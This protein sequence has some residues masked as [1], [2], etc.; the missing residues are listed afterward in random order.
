MAYW[1]A[2]GRSLAA[3]DTKNRADYI[4]DYLSCAG[5]DASVSRLPEGD[6]CAVTVPSSQQA[7]ADRLMRSYYA[8]QARMENERMSESYYRE[9]CLA[10]QPHFIPQEEKFRT[11]TH[12]SMLYTICG[13]IVFVLAVFHF[14]L[15]L[16]HRNPDDLRTCTLEL[17]LA[18]IFVLFGLS[19]QQKVRILQNK[20]LEENSFTDG[21]IRWCTS[22][23]S[24]EHI[25]KSIQA[26]EDTELTGP[27]LAVRR[28]ELIRD[29]ILREYDIS[30][31][32][33]LDY[34]TDTIYKKF[35]FPNSISGFSME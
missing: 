28:R 26:A 11:D 17:L 12:S 35:Y 34:I 23:Y 24:A 9:H 5:L 4:A 6:L 29:Y 18:C 31:A 16:R 15:M 33:Y 7:E 10:R 22:T 3:E 32:A 2:L 13:G 30:D 20:I 21:I 27:E 14:L 8:R 1:D 25:D 19:T